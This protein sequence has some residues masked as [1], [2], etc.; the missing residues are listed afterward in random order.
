M[1]GYCPQ[2]DHQMEVGL[3]DETAHCHWCGAAFTTEYLRHEPKND[4]APVEDGA[5]H[6]WFSLSY[7]NYMVLHRSLLQSMP[8]DWQQRFVNMLEELHERFSDVPQADSYWVR[9]R[10]GNRFIS[11]PVPHYDR[12]RTRIQP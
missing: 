3:F 2:C 7:S 5:I 11:D 9:A 4:K 6:T 12:G 10:D 8:L 1:I